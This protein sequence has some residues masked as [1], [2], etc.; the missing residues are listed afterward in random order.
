MSY[1][2]RD[3]I[4]YHFALAD[5]FTVLDNYYCSIMGPTNPNRCYLWTGS[6]GNV[7]YLSA[8]GTDGFGSGP[9]TSN[10]VSRLAV[11]FN[12][13]A[14]RANLSRDLGFSHEDRIEHARRMGCATAW[15]RPGVP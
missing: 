14:A 8:A 4:P 12:A 15:W 11:T 7:D 13:D 6:V 5:A 9:I 1:F 10:G 2:T 3:D